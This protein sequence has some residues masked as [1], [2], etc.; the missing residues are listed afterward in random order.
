MLVKGRGVEVEARLC[1][2]DLRVAHPSPLLS[3]GTICGVMVQVGELRVPDRSLDLVQ[4]LHC[5]IREVDV[6]RGADV[7]VDEVRREQTCAHDVLARQTLHLHVTITVICKM[8][9]EDLFLATASYVHV[10]LV[11]AICLVV[12]THAV[13]SLSTAEGHVHSSTRKQHLRVL[14]CDV[15]ATGEALCTKGRESCHVLTKVENVDC[16]SWSLDGHWC[17]AL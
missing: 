8:W 10:R 13:G 4:N 12:A 1:T 6:A 17:V 11:R 5:R 2:G 7:G 15:S 16:R 14:E 3:L 9:R